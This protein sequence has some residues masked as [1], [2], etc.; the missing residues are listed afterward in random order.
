MKYM[1]NIKLFYVLATT[2][3]ILGNASI[4]LD[5]DNEYDYDDTN[6]D[7]N[8]FLTQAIFANNETMS[9]GIF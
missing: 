1:C 3:K 6:D 2:F 4:D 5:D 9:K 7:D 8:T